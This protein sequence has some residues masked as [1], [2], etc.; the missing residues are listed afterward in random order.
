MDKREK[1]FVN[2][3]IDEL[4]GFFDFQKHED[5]Y[6]EGIP[7]LSYA[8]YDVDG[9][10]EVKY[11]ERLPV[12]PGTPLRLDHPLTTAQRRWLRRRG[13]EGGGRCFVLLGLGSGEV[14]LTHHTLLYDSY[15]TT[16]HLDEIKEVSCI[17]TNRKNFDRSA[18]V[19]ALTMKC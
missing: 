1:R 7:D 17:N 13:R 15:G 3:F 5:K 8:G 19:V 9:W 12:R 10:I 6:T 14:L 2:W 11:Q 4:R 18:M 16:M